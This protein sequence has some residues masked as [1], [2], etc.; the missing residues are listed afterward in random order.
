MYKFTA[1]L[2]RVENNGYPTKTFQV[3][4]AFGGAEDTPPIGTRGM[5]PP[6]QAKWVGGAW[7]LNPAVT[8]D[9]LTGKTNTYK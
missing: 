2:I 9:A 8:I 6:L 4:E 3:V 7:S 1:T 5:L